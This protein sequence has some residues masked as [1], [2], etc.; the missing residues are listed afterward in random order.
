[1]GEPSL[2]PNR[3]GQVRPAKPASAFFACH[4]LQRRTASASTPLW[5]RT[6]FALAFS[7]ALAVRN[8]RASARN[9]ASSGVSLKSMTRSSLRGVAGFEQID[10]AVLPERGRSDRQPELFGSPVEQMAV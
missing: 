10:E 6:G 9:A 7:S 3:L 1:M 8:A 4:S 5:R 2:P